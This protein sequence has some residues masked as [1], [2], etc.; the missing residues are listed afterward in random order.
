MLIA[1][2]FSTLLTVA[3]GIAVFTGLICFVLK[4]YSRA[5]YTRPRHYINSRHGPSMYFT[6]DTGKRKNFF[7]LLFL[8]KI[9][10]KIKITR[11]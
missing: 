2:D 10:L 11:K 9:S 1:K 6:S 3:S 5:R 7:L 4:L 8:L